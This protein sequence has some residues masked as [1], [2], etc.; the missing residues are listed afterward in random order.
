M[1]VVVDF[2]AFKSRSNSFIL[3]ELAIVSCRDN[4]IVHYFIK[5]PQ[6]YDYLCVDFQKRINYTTDNIHNIPWD[7]GH[8]E[9]KDALRVLNEFVRSA[10]VVYVKGSERKTY[11]EKIIIWDIPVVDLDNFN[12]PKAYILPSALLQLCPFGGHFKTDWRCALK[13]AQKY[14]QWINQQKNYK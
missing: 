11:L 5:P 6:P 9:F 7:Y 13:N 4:T 2:Q 8:V 12:C 3:K 10:S 1:A 14:K